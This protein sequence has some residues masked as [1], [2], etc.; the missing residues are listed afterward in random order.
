MYWE[1][2]TRSEQVFLW[3]SQDIFPLREIFLPNAGFPTV[4]IL[5]RELFKARMQWFLHYG[6]T[7]FH[8]LWIA[9]L[10]ML[11]LPSEKYT[12]AES[13]IMKFKRKIIMGGTESR[14]KSI[15][16]LRV[17]LLC[18]YNIM[19][20]HQNTHCI[21]LDVYQFRNSLTWLTAGKERLS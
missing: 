12:H 19:M 11:K 20:Y 14:I 13:E 9:N 15:L 8:F 17:C 6:K 4:A 16:L 3:R 10:L 21:H 1:E 2:C 7:L 18:C 5:T